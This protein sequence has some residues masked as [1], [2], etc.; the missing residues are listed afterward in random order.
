MVKETNVT[1]M[2]LSSG[3]EAR[4]LSRANDTTRFLDDW[5]GSGPRGSEP[6][7]PSELM[8]AMRH[9]VLNGGKRFRP[10]LV[11]E[12]AL[13]AGA[14]ETAIKGAAYVAAALEAIHCYSLIHDDLPSMDDDTVRR[15]K[16]T[17]HVV[18]GDATA[19]LAGDALLTEAFTL[20]CAEENQIDSETKCKVV[21]IFA[22]AA[23]CGGM[24]GGQHHDMAQQSTQVDETGIIR[25]QAMKTGALIRAA[26]ETG[27]LIAGANK[28]QFEALS[29]YGATIGLIFQ[30]ADDLLDRTSDAAALG[31]TTGKDDKAGKQT[32]VSLHGE[33]WARERLDALVADAHVAVE[34][35]GERG[36]ILR[37]AARFAAYRQN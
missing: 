13:A 33:H 1:N 29:A 8:A 36:A 24:V 11:L 20:V 14:T 3:F 7:R 18:Y 5:L 19:I 31:K 17:V 37:D 16:P 12:T 26:C 15:G 6:D 32:L 22:Q 30:I 28:I 21:Q 9:G 34:V 10:F 27:A 2:P 35:F 4:L 23:G 25:T